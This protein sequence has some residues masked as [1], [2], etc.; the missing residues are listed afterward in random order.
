ME[1]YKKLLPYF[2]AFS[3]FVVEA[4]TSV[5]VC[6]HFC[7]VQ[8]GRQVQ[9]DMDYT[10]PMVHATTQRNLLICNQRAP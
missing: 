4:Q 2:F 1:G 10:E 5:C 3:F 9:L 8:L 6:V 7:R